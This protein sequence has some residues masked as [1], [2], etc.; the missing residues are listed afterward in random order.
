MSILKFGMSFEAAVAFVGVLQMQIY[1][2]ENVKVHTPLPARTSD[3][4]GVKP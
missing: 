4:T 3:E 2:E 1:P